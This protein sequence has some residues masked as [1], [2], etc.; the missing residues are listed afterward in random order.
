[1]RGSRLSDEGVSFCIMINLWST[2]FNE[3]VGP[4]SLPATNQ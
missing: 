1:M 4:A 2:N 3:L